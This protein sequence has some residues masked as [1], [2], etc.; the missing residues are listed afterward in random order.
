[1]SISASQS[2]SIVVR[3]PRSHQTLLAFGASLSK[4]RF[5]IASPLLDAG[6][7]QPQMGM[8]WRKYIELYRWKESQVAGRGETLTQTLFPNADA[9]AVPAPAI[10][11]AGAGAGAGAATPP[12]ERLDAAPV[13]AGR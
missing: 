7:L 2:A 12:V 8:D 1:M 13:E 10:A 3:V 5:S 4:L 6:Q 11:G 9:L